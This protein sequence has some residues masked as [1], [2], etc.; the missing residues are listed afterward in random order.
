MFF[1]PDQFFLTLT[2]GN[3]NELWWAISSV[4]KIVHAFFWRINPVSTGMGLVY[5][6][7]APFV[8]YC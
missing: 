2:M 3:S 8:E 1:L 6:Y 4:T 7:C 5:I